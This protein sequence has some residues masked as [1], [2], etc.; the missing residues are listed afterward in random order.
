MNHETISQQDA[1]IAMQSAK[2]LRREAWQVVKEYEASGRAL[3]YMEISVYY[4]LHERAEAASAKLTIVRNVLNGVIEGHV[5]QS[6]KA[7]QQ[8]ADQGGHPE[9]IP[10]LRADGSVR[11]RPNWK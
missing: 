8:Y 1:E 5:D 2:A 6:I 10:D 3:P 9:H 7:K 11:W 4:G